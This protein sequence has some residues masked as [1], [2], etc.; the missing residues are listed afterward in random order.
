MGFLP[1][2]AHRYR[3]TWFFLHISSEWH[4]FLAN[5]FKMPRQP[6]VTEI[7]VN[8]I[9][10]LLEP[11]KTLLNELNDA[12][13]TSFVQAISNTITSLITA[14]QVRHTYHGITSLTP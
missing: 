3:V 13:G 12:F 11:A 14:I 10:A 4:H 8:N 9:I 2:P 6:P 1:I 7:R 5:I